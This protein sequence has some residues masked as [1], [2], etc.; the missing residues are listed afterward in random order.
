[1]RVLVT[2][3]AGFVGRATV[4]A[5]VE[6]GHEVRIVSRDARPSGSLF[7]HLG[8]EVVTGDAQ[9]PP[10][11]ERPCRA[12][13]PSSRPRRPTATTAR[14]APAMANNA[15]LARTILE[16]APE[17]APR[18]SSTSARCR[19]CARP[20]AGDE[21]TPLTTAGGRRL[22]DPY[23]RSKVECGARRPRAR[24][25][26]SATGH[27]PPWHRYRPRGHRDGHEQRVS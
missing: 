24:G 10:V 18:R 5:L 7:D 3:G 2:G 1:M 12:W 11:I 17:P 9:D 16:A 21:D 19:L 26:G 20:H 23:L 8:V 25:G 6:A 27:D 4:R 14:L 13:T 22:G 15:P